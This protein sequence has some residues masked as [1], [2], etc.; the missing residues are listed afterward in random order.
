MFGGFSQLSTTAERAV[1]KS[2]STIVRDTE[3]ALGSSRNLRGAA[4]NLIDVSE[5]RICRLSFEF[6]DHILLKDA[7]SSAAS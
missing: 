1:I 4:K 6:R 7:V 5:K 3:T 2:L